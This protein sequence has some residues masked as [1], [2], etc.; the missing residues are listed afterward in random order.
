[1]IERLGRLWRTLRHLRPVQLWGRVPFML[2]RRLLAH[3]LPPSLVKEA[4]RLVV[5][6]PAPVGMFRCVHGG[7]VR[8]YPLNAVPWTMI[9]EDDP[10]LDKLWRYTLHY[11]DW[12]HDS[13]LTWA[14]RRFLLFDWIARN[15]DSRAESWEPYVVSRRLINWIRLLDD[16][17]CRDRLSAAEIRVIDR[18]VRVQVKRLRIDI[19]YHQ[20]ANHLLENLMTLCVAS[21]YLL[22]SPTFPTRR[23][24]TRQWLQEAAQG[25]LTELQEQILPDGAHYERCPM[26]HEEILTSLERVST[27][28]RRAVPETLTDSASAAVTVLCAHLEMV[29]PR[30]R[31]WADLLT[32][33]DGCCAQFHDS[34][35]AP[36]RHAWAWA[37]PVSLEGQLLSASGFFVAR[38]PGGHYFALDCGEPN[39][40]HQPGHS[41]ASILSCE[42]SVDG[43][44]LVI[45]TGVG[46]Y[47]D[48]QV[49]RFCRSSL[50]HN[51]PL[52]GDADQSELWSSFRMGGRCRVTARQWDAVR[53]RLRVEILD[54]RGNRL[55]REV[56][57]RDDGLI[58]IDQVLKRATEGPWRVFWHLAVDGDAPIPAV[59]GQTWRLPHAGRE[60]LL[61]ASVAGTVEGTC[62]YPGFGVSRPTQNIVL[63]GGDDDVI[64]SSFFW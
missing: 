14:A 18:A 52:V 47:H 56:V 51:L 45:D 13:R 36:A 50:A 15:A 57:L 43:R 34:T 5:A 25:L 19:E 10:A 48:P 61:E 7:Q 21:A 64:T 9:P 4:V 54:W 22:T 12:L 58:V 28:G 49:R 46:S 39:P 20:S 53:H 27:W 44:R 63:Q 6:T 23:G 16:P 32:H 38:W 30:M 2:R 59:N 60:V 37:D 29:L 8:E 33:P 11:G 1:M 55:Q 17:T 3:R 24:T 42:L 31:A 62:C 40:P 35:R 41:H 26:Y